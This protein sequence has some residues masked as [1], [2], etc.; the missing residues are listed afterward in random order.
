MALIHDNN[1]QNADDALDL[2][3]EDTVVF[4]QE[5]QVLQWADNI[6]NQSHAEQQQSV[7]REEFVELLTAYRKLIGVTKRVVR[8]SD[9]LQHDLKSLN[10]FKNHMLGVV[11]HDLR[12]P[13]ATI[14]GLAELLLDD[15]SD[16][17][18]GDQA[19]FVQG[20]YRA[21]NEMLA[22]LNNLLDVSMIE[23]GRLVLRAVPVDFATLIR[24]RIELLGLQAE[25]KSIILRPDLE[26]PPEIECDPDRISQVIDN[27]VGN[28]IKFSPHHATIDLLLRCDEALLTFAV[29]DHGPGIPADEINRLF[30]AFQKLSTRPTAGE[31]GSGFGLA[32]VRKIVSAHNG[33]IDVVSEVGKGTTFTVRLPLSRKGE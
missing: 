6:L 28:A 23:S 21:S 7:T 2:M 5:Q 29:R 33:Q 19:R 9:L 26:Q 8:I 30:G 13:C 10:E 11:A 22:L 25:R 16:C 12:N 4:R 14:I 15:S 3:A 32:I 24:Q 20:I 27:L 31:P 17:V 18:N 1:T